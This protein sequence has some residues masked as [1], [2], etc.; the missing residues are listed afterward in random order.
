MYEQVLAAVLGSDEPEALV[1]VEP[2]DGSGWHVDCLQVRVLA[3]RRC[4]LETSTA[5]TCTSLPGVSGLT[6]ASVATVAA[7][8]RLRRDRPLLRPERP[9]L[10]VRAAPRLVQ[11]NDPQV[12]VVARRRT[13]V[14]HLDT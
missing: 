5:P 7:L 6:R 1:G 3:T 2:L 9:L 11:A 12:A 13:V 10:E 14:E 4:S 8:L